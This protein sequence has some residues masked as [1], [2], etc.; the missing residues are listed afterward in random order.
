SLVPEVAFQLTDDRR[1][2]IGG[3]LHLPC[4]VEPVDRLDQADGPHLDEIV[5]GLTASGESPGEVFDQAE[6]SLD[7][8]LPYLR[9]LGPA[10]LSKEAS[11]LI[12]GQLRMAFVRDQGGPL[13]RT[14]NVN[15]AWPSVSSTS[16]SS[17]TDRKMV[18]DHTFSK[19]APGLVGASPAAETPRAPSST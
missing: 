12:L 5:E 9:V 19:V 10:E 4:R 13:L 14:R 15:R 2:G 6:M 18:S 3:E 7:Q 8:T 17:V 11:D 1:G 16:I